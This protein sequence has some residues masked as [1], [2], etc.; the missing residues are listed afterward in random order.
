MLKPVLALLIHDIPIRN[1]V[2]TPNCESLFENNRFLFSLPIIYY[3]KHKTQH[4]QMM[5]KT[6]KDCTYLEY[7]NFSW[8]KDT[9]RHLVQEKLQLQY[10]LFCNSVYC[11]LLYCTP[12]RTRN[13][14]AC[15]LQGGSLPNVLSCI[16]STDLPT[17]VVNG[18]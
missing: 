13:N 15:L 3:R 11:L 5:M 14:I 2:G 8:K 12:H 10:F 6:C 16:I 4:C 17:I 9:S 18:L 7:T 1:I